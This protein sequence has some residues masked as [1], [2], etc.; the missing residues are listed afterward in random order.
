MKLT[1]DQEPEAMPV[2]MAACSRGNENDPTFSATIWNP[3][4][5]NVDSEINAIAMGTDVVQVVKPSVSETRLKNA[6]NPIGRRLLAANRSAI[7]PQKKY[8]I[9]QVRGGIQAS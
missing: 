9:P 7:H 2:I 8:P 5:M 6:K 4:P 1:S 3:P